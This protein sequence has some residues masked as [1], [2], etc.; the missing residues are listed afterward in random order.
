MTQSG[1][2]ES[3]STGRPG[4][5]FRKIDGV[6]RTFEQRLWDAGIFT[7]RDLAQ[8]TGKNS[9]WSWDPWLGYFPNA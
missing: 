1:D 4:D 7:Y 6:G 5:D 8:R 3:S 9:P 2:P